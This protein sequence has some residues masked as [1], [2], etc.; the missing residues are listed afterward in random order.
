MKLN[1][2]KKKEIR[3]E[4]DRPLNMKEGIREKHV[5]ENINDLFITPTIEKTM[6]DKKRVKI[7]KS[8]V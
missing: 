1:I 8:G 7:N 3:S 5:E 6:M 2:V 4:C